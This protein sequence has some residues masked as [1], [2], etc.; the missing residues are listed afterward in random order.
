MAN[1]KR[2]H[3]KA[4]TAKRRAVY[5]SSLEKPEVMECENCGNPKMRHRACPTC[6]HYRGRQVIER[7]EEY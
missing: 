7:S 3:S 6:G 5:Y 2:K 4:R 1:P